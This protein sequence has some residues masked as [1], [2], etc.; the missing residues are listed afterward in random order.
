MAI[1]H[2]FTWGGCG[3]LP[4]GQAVEA[5]VCRAVVGG[6]FLAEVEVSRCAHQ[7]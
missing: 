1:A 4:A 5:G 6:P 3:L 7:A 2:V